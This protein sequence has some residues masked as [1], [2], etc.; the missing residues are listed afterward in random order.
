MKTGFRGM[1]LALAAFIVP[2]MFVR[3][4]AL[5]LDGNITTIISVLIT[6]M[7]GIYALAAGLV[8]YLVNSRI[9][10]VQRV[11]LLIAALLL[12]DPGFNT[13]VIGVIIFVAVFLIGKFFRKKVLSL[14]N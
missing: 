13:D 2:F 10:M 7:I 6:S 11:L 3:S 8:G 4:P 1:Q 14:E 9:N 12:M 5:M